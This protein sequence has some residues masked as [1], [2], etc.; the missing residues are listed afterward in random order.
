MDR[1]FG[2]CHWDDLRRQSMHGFQFR[3]MLPRRC[4]KPN[5]PGMSF[6]PGEPGGRRIWRPPCASLANSVIGVNPGTAPKPWEP[7]LL[8][9]A[10]LLADLNTAITSYTPHTLGH[11]DNVAIFAQ[12]VGS[13]GPDLYPSDG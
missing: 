11:D 1:N 4:R 9:A 3:A 6:L 7:R 13:S 12:D 2:S 10:S 5:R 8:L